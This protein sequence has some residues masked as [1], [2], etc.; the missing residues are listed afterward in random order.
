MA[1]L[2]HDPSDQ[3]AETPRRVRSI[4]VTEMWA[5]LAIVVI[6]LAVLFDAV[7]GPDI[8]THDVSGSGATIPSAVVVAFFAFLATRVIARRAFGDERPTD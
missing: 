6:W 7:F 5:A 3:I 8:L 4:L 1:A 2:S